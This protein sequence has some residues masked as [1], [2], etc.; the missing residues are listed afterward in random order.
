LPALPSLLCLSRSALAHPC[1]QAELSLQL[2]PPAAESDDDVPSDYHS[3]SEDDGGEE[4][5]L[6]LALPPKVRPRVI[7][8]PCV[9]C[10]VACLRAQCN[11]NVLDAPLHPTGNERAA[12]QDERGTPR[13]P[14]PAHS[15]LPPA[16]APAAA[17][18]GG[19]R[20]QH[21]LPQLGSFREKEWRTAYLHCVWGGACPGKGCALRFQFQLASCS[22]NLST[23]HD[24]VVAQGGIDK[25]RGSGGG[26]LGEGGG[27]GMRRNGN[28][29]LSN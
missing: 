14:A 2:T 7:V 1:T 10:W 17:G 4:G 15:R 28:M 13:F 21:Q 6:A 16:A 9:R 26:R 23:L 3:V 11:A 27:L 20:G 8:L 24:A 19:A 12:E 5:L 22:Y 29:C 18:A 25:V